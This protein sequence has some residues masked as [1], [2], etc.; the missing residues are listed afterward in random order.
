MESCEKRINFSKGCVFDS[1]KDFK[2]MLNSY[3]RLSKTGYVTVKSQLFKNGEDKRLPYKMK[4]YKC[5]QHVRKWC[6]AS[7]RVC[8]KEAG[9][10]KNKYMVTQF[11]L[12]HTHDLDNQLS[13]IKLCEMECSDTESHSTRSAKSA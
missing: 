5:E 7:I 13:V 12:E 1:F 10:H 6:K 9:K 11:K 2:R 4:Y 3:S 8:L